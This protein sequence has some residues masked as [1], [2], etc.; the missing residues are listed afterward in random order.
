MYV[1]VK[2]LLYNG[3]VIGFLCHI[4]LQST[5]D[6]MVLTD[7]SNCVLNVLYVRNIALN[8][9]NYSHSS[10]AFNPP[11]PTNKKAHRKKTKHLYIYFSVEEILE[12]M[13]M[14]KKSQTLIWREKNKTA[15][16]RSNGFG[17][18]GCLALTSTP[19]QETFISNSRN[20]DS[21]QSPCFFKRNAQSEGPRLVVT[22][23]QAAI[24]PHLKCRVFKMCLTGKLLMGVTH[25]IASTKPR[26][27]HQQSL[28]SANQHLP[29]GTSKSV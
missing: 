4:E 9:V 18:L 27:V 8:K 10:W 14:N 12:L 2:R 25:H 5:C 16:S 15:Q 17:L 24:I 23:R 26:S 13:N 21:K 29:D 7:I 19:G 11:P 28:F 6:Q 20:D 3:T 1:Q 22:W